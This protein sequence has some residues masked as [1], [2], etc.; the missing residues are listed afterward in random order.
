MGLAGCRRALVILFVRR[1]DPKRAR[2][3]I[4]VNYYRGPHKVRGFIQ[5]FTFIRLVANPKFGIT[6]PIFGIGSQQVKW[7]RRGGWEKIG[8]SFPL[9][10]S[11][12]YLVDPS[13]GL[14][15]GLGGLR[16]AGA[17]F[18]WGV[19]PP[20]HFVGDPRLRTPRPSNSFGSLS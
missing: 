2:A 11:P 9:P 6:N 1:F 13:A 18:D 4:P 17:T 5:K 10:R 20:P 16:G 15:A 3:I 14:L 19:A 7:E 12:F 8:Q